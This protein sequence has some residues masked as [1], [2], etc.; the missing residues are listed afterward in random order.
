MDS[1]VGNF[2][3]AQIKA[4]ENKRTFHDWMLLKIWGED[5][6]SGLTTVMLGLDKD[7]I[8]DQINAFKGVI[9]EKF[10]EGV[11]DM[12]MDIE[13]I[14]DEAKHEDNKEGEE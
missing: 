3:D 5:N 8:E 9:R 1:R 10:T 11:P 12:N 2:S 14:L 13:D 4:G 7:G 6:L